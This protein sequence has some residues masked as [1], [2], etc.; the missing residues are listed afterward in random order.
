MVEIHK[1]ESERNTVE[2]N[3]GRS[4]DIAESA[5]AFVAV[6]GDSV[7]QSEND[8]IAAVIVVIA[9]RASMR[10]AG[11]I[12]TGLRGH[13]GKS[14]ASGVAIKDCR[15]VPFGRQ[16]Q[17][18]PAVGIEVDEARAGAGELQEPIGGPAGVAAR[19]ARRTMGSPQNERRNP[20]ERLP[21]RRQALPS[22]TGPAHR[23]SG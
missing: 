14:A 16:Q 15:A 2:T 18:W 10:L 21:R 9:N 12:E 8:V 17:V 20:E 13:V 7:R 3:A 6:N 22:N 19:C 1:G 23:R 4:R 11:G 5:V